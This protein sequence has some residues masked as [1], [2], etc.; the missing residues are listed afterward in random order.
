MK[1]DCTRPLDPDSSVTI[2]CNVHFARILHALAKLGQANI[3]VKP[4]SAIAHDATEAELRYIERELE[5][6]LTP[7]PIVHY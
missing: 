4:A 3:S 1:V 2:T 6:A 7:K 5:S